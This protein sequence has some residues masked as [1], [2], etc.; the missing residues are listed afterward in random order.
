MA[1]KKLQFL[2]K[3]TD[4]LTQI[5]YRTAPPAPF[6]RRSVQACFFNAGGERE[7]NT[8]H[9]TAKISGKEGLRIAKFSD[10]S[11]NKKKRG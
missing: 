1:S 6:W 9:N 10:K 2:E 11:A 4:L 3:Y 8:V 7:Q 5:E